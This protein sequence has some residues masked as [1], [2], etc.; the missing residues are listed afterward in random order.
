M[1]P[2]ELKPLM[3]QKLWNSKAHRKTSDSYEGTLREFFGA[4]LDFGK[5]K[6]DWV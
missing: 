2:L 5:G 4:A 1:V 6:K 3:G